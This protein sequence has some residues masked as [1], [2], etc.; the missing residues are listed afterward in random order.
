[1]VC[2]RETTCA[3]TGHR[4]S[5]L[6]EFGAEHLPL[7]QQLK[8]VIYNEIYSAITVG[9]DTFITGMAMGFDIIAGETVLAFKVMYPE[10]KLYAAVPF[11]SQQLKF[12][13]IWKR[14]YDNL[15]RACDG[16]ELLS[17][18]Y[19]KGCFGDRNKF[20][21]DNCSRIIAYLD[22]SESSGTR[23]TVRYAKSQGVEVINCVDSL[24]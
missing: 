16:F 10:I 15:L 23:S 14:R 9:Y 1:M 11:E 5:K 18:S 4:P 12:P 20:M 19:Y 13:L 2:P 21:V 24:I 7:M 6:P 17:K 8:Q 3:F 22:A